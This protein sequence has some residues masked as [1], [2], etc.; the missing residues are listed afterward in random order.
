MSELN[1]PGRVLVP[2]NPFPHNT[3]WLN[4]GIVEAWQ[5][6]WCFARAGRGNCMIFR[7][8]M[9]A[10]GQVHS[11]HP[12]FGLSDPHLKAEDPRA[13]YDPLRDRIVLYYAGILGPGHCAIFRAEIDQAGKVHGRE[14]LRYL[15]DGQG[16]RVVQRAFAVDEQK[17]WAPFIADGRELCI[18]HHAP[19]T[20]LERTS[21]GMR[22]AHKGPSISWDYGE[23]RGGAPPVKVGDVFYSIFHSARFDRDPDTGKESKVY[24][25]G[26]LAFTDDFGLAAITPEPILAGNVAEGNWPWTAPGIGVA[27]SACF[28]C[29]AI[30]RGENLLV[31]YGWLD[32]EVRLAEIPIAELRE[33]M[34]EPEPV[35]LGARRRI[36][37]HDA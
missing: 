36:V 28:P 19:W 11:P 7:L 34:V 8:E 13:I 12:L 22:L 16:V 4:A 23:I 32:Q 26:C 31:S 1:V 21:E 5:K 30:V 27:V 10:A 24:Y 9:D 15:D 2:R 18:Y 17:N 25:A 6:T 33:R 14:Q 37:K 29:G 3:Y 20:I 35:A